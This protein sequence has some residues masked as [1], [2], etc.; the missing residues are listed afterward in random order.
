MARF[1]LQ[2]QGCG[3]PLDPIDTDS[4]TIEAY[5]RLCTGCWTMLLPCDLPTFLKVTAAIASD[6]M[7]GWVQDPIGPPPLARAELRRAWILGAL[8]C[9]LD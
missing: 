4:R 6:T 2:C 5:E 8:K 3:R 1:Y 9:R 7:L